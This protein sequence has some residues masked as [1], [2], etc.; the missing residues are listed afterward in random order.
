MADE[1]NKLNTLA[2]EANTIIYE[3]SSTFPFQL[4]PDKIVIDENKVTIFRRELFFQR[5]Y[6]ILIEDILTI[7]LDEG[8]LFSSL[9]FSANKFINMKRPLTYLKPEEAKKARQYIM[10][11]VQAK[12][13][14]I[15]LSKLTLQEIR[16]KLEEIGR[17]QE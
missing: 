5:T 16:I 9:T 1:I 4:F 12:K 6:P 11:L 8:I 10:G 3:L 15:D 7:R 17:T 14:K 2:Q 13:A